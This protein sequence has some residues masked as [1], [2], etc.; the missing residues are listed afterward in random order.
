MEISAWVMWVVIAVVF[1]IFEMFTFT[2][3]TIWFAVGAGVAAL[4][5]YLGLHPGYQWTSFA[6]VALVLVALTR[7]VARRI[8][9]KFQTKGIGSDRFAGLR[10][11]VTEGID[12]ALNKGKVKLEREE[13]EWLALSET[14]GKISSGTEVEVER[15]EGTKLIVKEV[16]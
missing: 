8:T 5:A 6:V 3:L 11:V 15:L 2:F 10:G 16:K 9:S 13:Y 1:A 7:R 4:L 14:G 12:P